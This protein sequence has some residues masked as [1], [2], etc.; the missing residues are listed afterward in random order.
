MR[1]DHLVSVEGRAAV[2]ERVA[3]AIVAVERPHP[4]R[5]G[6]DGYLAAARP[7]ERADIVVDNTEP[8]RP[9]LVRG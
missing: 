9:V 5:V 7:H 4:L 3:T 2:L 8:G 6:I 1:D